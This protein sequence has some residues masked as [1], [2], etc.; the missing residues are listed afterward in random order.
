MGDGRRRGE[1]SES[2]KQ[3]SGTYLGKV[4]KPRIQHCA[5]LQS[6]IWKKLSGQ[7]FKSSR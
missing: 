3:T 7:E 6:P 2:L 4:G 1:N 5:S